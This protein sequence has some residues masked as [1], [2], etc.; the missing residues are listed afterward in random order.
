MVE[1]QLSVLITGDRM[2]Y[3][4]RRRRLETLG[5]GVVLVRDQAS[6]GVRV[7]G[8]ELLRGCL[9]GERSWGVNWAS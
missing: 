6:V 5:I 7:R 4:G 1:R 8:G 2:L 3:R 9:I